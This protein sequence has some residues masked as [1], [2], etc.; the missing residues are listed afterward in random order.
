MFENVECKPVKLGNFELELGRI[1]RVQLNVPNYRTIFSDFQLL[2]LHVSHLVIKVNHTD[3]ILGECNDIDKEEVIHKLLENSQTSFKT[4]LIQYFSKCV[5]LQ[6][7]N[8]R[9]SIRKNGA[10]VRLRGKTIHLENNLTT[11]E[12]VSCK[13]DNEKIMDPVNFQF[14][15]G[16]FDAQI[17]GI[18]IN[19]RKDQVARLMK[20]L[21]AKNDPRP[22]KS[23]IFQK[24]IR[25]NH[26]AR[27]RK[28]KNW[29]NVYSYCK[30]YIA[31]KKLYS[32]AQS[33][34]DA[35]TVYPIGEYSN[36]PESA[37]NDDKI[38]ECAN[39]W[40]IKRQLVDYERRLSAEIIA[41]YRYF[42]KH[43]IHRIQSGSK[44]NVDTKFEFRLEDQLGFSIVSTDL[45]L[46]TD[47]GISLRN[48]EVRLRER[49]VCK[50]KHI[51]MHDQM[52]IQNFSVVYDDE[53]ICDNVCVKV[54]PKSNSIMSVNHVTTLD[55]NLDFVEYLQDFLKSMN[56]LVPKSNK[57]NTDETKI[58]N[59]AFPSLRINL[60]DKDQHLVDVAMSGLETTVVKSGDVLQVSTRL[61]E[62]QVHHETSE[63]ISARN[64]I[65]IQLRF[66]SIERMVHCDFHE[67]SLL[68]SPEQIAILQHYLQKRYSNAEH[69]ENAIE[70]GENSQKTP[71]SIRISVA[72]YA[73]IKFQKYFRNFVKLNFRQSSTFLFK[74]KVAGG[75][76]LGIDLNGAELLDESLDHGCSFYKK[77]NFRDVFSLQ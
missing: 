11:F 22:T 47:S 12:G 54:C 37:N 8:V 73:S 4:Q 52:M 75:A 45:I 24:I 44:F 58:Y 23:K 32:A 30:D 13:L 26:F 33:L 15:L 5:V 38:A 3:D 72:E 64:R 35:N 62:I 19:V 56:D 67:F 16:N 76:L 25:N 43:R 65:D 14:D 36:V 40:D 10:S 17:P 51:R 7:D 66:S 53:E 77:V 21:P 69:R 42:I 46:N 71:F 41:D 9:I 68:W 1:G 60:A 27:I 70:N 34:A 59:I 61:T 57:N 31:Y 29:R 6:C 2:H 63:L 49:L 50:I 48:T 18:A 20:F 74:T 55:L 28:N 39:F